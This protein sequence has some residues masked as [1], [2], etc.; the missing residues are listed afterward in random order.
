MDPRSALS[1][2]GCRNIDHLTASEGHA[3]NPS[4]L[5][6]RSSRLVGRKCGSESK[7]ERRSSSCAR[8]SKTGASPPPLGRSV[9]R[10]FSLDP[11]DDE[12]L[13][14]TMP[15]HMLEPFGSPAHKHDATAPFHAIPWDGSSYSTTIMIIDSSSGSITDLL[16]PLSR[17]D[18]NP[19]APVFVERRYRLRGCEP[20]ELEVTTRI[21]R[22]SFETCTNRPHWAVVAHQYCASHRLVVATRLESRGE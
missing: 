2:P 1:A 9:G 11:L 16:L 12:A 14:L 21:D 17:P 22:S 5:A 10:S 6:G 3:T 8:A 4:A 15:G 18:D 13:H 19:A 7:R 20:A